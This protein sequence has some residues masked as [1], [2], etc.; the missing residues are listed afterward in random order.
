MKIYCE[1]GA[2]TKELKALQASGK[3]ELLHFPYDPGSKSK[4]L[5]TEIVPSQAQ[6]RDMNVSWAEVRGSWDD[7]RGSIH[8]A[9]ILSIIGPQ[10]RR[11][12]LHVDTAY[13]AGCHALVTVDSDILVHKNELEQLLDIRICH[14]ETHRDELLDLF[15]GGSA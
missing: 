5:S 9:R 15:R 8:Y 1:H 11:D 6:W 2:L 13:K 3:I 7:S 14:P 12:A 4:H 10:H